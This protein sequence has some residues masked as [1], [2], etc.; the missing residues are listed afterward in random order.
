MQKNTLYSL[1]ALSIVGI[2]FSVLGGIY[3]VLGAILSN[4]SG[5]EGEDA[6]VGPIFLGI[7]CLF[8]VFG[9][10]FLLVELAKKKQAEALVSAGQYVW[11]EIVEFSSNYN[12][13]VNNRH[14]YVAVVRY[15]DAMGTVHIFR[16]RNLKS[17]PD[18]TAVGKQVKIYFKNESYKPYYV[19][20]AGLLGHV[21]EH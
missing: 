9:V 13:R 20:M 5:L 8:L 3:A 18:T 16:S 15:R 4:V 19:D 6:L 17:Y 11:G 10:V 7:G 1:S 12:V 2:V 14:P 21:V